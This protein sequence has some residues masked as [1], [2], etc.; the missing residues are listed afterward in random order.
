MA[1]STKKILAE[2]IL[3]RIYGGTPDT[4]APIQEED[5]F[6][7]LE[8][9]INSL[10]KLRQFDTTLP[11]GETIP[12]NS[13]LATY[14]DITVTSLGNG[15]S[16]ALLPVQPISLP[17]SVGIFLVYDPANPDNP[18]IPVQRGQMALLK[19][20]SLLNNM[21]GQIAYEPKNNYV[22]FNRDLT[23]FGVNKVT[24]ELCVMDI[25]QYSETQYLP[26]PSD[27]EETIVNEL[28]AQFSPV[29]PES[30]IV[31]PITNSNQKANP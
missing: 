26:I 25:S 13:M 12:D 18:F 22:E 7:A 29:T 4:S 10:F 15:K 6:K 17:K 16:K 9:K 14:E 1:N 28:V 5:V 8:Q 20:D 2:Q 11:S 24:F 23:T 3:Y 19:V 21:M 27:M 31:N 30:G